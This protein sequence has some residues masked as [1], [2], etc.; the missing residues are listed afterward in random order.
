MFL[1]LT[2]ISLTLLFIYALAVQYNDPDPALWV[3]IYGLAAVAGLLSLT[4]RLPW[5]FPVLLGMVC[6]AAG[7]VLSLRVIGQQTLLGSEEGR[8]MLGLFVTALWMGVLAYVSH[9]RNWQHENK[10]QENFP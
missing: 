4:K 6:L 10:P 1:R 8:E 7:L 3:A 9:T 5:I 2:T